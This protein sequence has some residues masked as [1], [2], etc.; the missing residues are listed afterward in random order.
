ME[1]FQNHNVACVH[2]VAVIRHD[3]MS[4][5]L[6]LTN[7]FMLQFTLCWGDTVWQSKGRTRVVA[8]ARLIC[9][10]P[11]THHVL[12]NGLLSLAFF[13]SLPVTFHLSSCSCSLPNGSLT[14]QLWF[15]FFYYECIWNLMFT[16][17][18]F[19][20]SYYCISWKTSWE[21][22]LLQCFCDITNA[23][24][25]RVPS[26]VGVPELVILWRSCRI[27]RWWA[28]RARLLSYQFVSSIWFRFI[29]VWTMNLKQFLILSVKNLS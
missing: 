27:H 18:C 5:S 10:I 23:F 11:S 6:S 9:P 20:A 4:A 8:V 29:D 7:W 1:F 26:F 24:A 16:L 2:L 12:I 28:W 21:E 19:I 22:A 14:I 3:R 17:M 25:I 13:I 15:L